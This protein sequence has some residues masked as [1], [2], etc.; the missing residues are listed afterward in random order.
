ME[1]TKI[2]F[3][4]VISIILSITISG[5]NPE[6][7]V[8]ITVIFGILVIIILLDEIKDNISIFLSLFNKYEIRIKDLAVILKIVMIAYICDFI[9]LLCKD[10][11]YESIGK[12]VEM[13]GKVIILIYSVDVIKVFLDEIL[14]LVKG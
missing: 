11:N 2:V 1:L 4:A 14:L 3:I 10:M 9:S 13:A 12:K 6:F 7:K 5:F 8:Y